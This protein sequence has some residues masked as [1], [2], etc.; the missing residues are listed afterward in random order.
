MIP[1]DTVGQRFIVDKL[2]GAGGMGAVYRSH[3]AET[4][5]PVAIKVLLEGR[6]QGDLLRFEREARALSELAHPGVVRYVERGLSG[7]GR[8]YLAMEWIEGESLA[9][10][11][12]R[13]PL[14][15]D[16]T[17][18]LGIRVAEALGAA[19]RRGIVHRDLKPSNILLQ[20]SA[21]DR[22]KLA[23]FGLAA[24]PESAR[25]TT[26][27][28]IVGTP[29]YMAPEQA[30]GAH[31][32]DARTDVFA[33][34]CVLHEC[35]TGEA[36]FEAH[37][38]MAVL[39]KIV[40]EEVPR[41]RDLGHRVPASLDALIARML[42]KDP[43]ARPEDGAAVAAI[44]SEIEAERA[45]ML[46]GASSSWHLPMTGLTG[47]EQRLASVVLA[48]QPK[49]AAYSPMALTLVC[50][51]PS[52]LQAALSAAAARGG[53]PAIL[54][55]GTIA[56]T[57]G[58]AG[59]ATDHAAI[60]AGCALALRQ[61]VPDAAVAIATGRAEVASERA[62]GDAIERAAAMIRERQRKGSP[63]IDLD[64]VTAGLLDLRFEV[65]AGPL[66]L[67]LSGERE[68][69]EAARTLLGRPTPFVGRRREIATIEALLDECEDERAARAVLVT[70][71]SGMGKSRLR[72]EITRRLAARGGLEVWIARGD[73]MRADAAFGVVV[74]LVRRAA[75]LLVGEPVAAQRQKLLARVSRHVSAAERLRVAEFLGEIAGAPFPDE[76]RVQLRAARRDPRL[77]SDQ[78]RRAFVD[79][80]SAEAAAQPLALVL[81][82]MHWGDAPSV[83]LIDAALAGLAQRPFLVLALARPE[84]HDRLPKL[85]RD[86]ALQEIRLT[87]LSR[88]DG[89]R[90]V[91]EVL[92]EGAPPETVERLLAR[93]Q[94]NV[95]FLEELL[96]ATA[97]GRDAELPETMLAM[98]ESR[99][100]ALSAEDRRLLRAASVLGEV[101]WRGG[102][103]AL[104]GPGE[105]SDERLARLSELEWISRRPTAKFRGEQEYAFRHAL[106]RE[107]AYGM[108]TADDRSL[109]H[110]L[111]AAWLESAGETDAVV[112]AE[113]FE[114]GEDSASAVRWYC[115]AAEQAVEGN[116]LASVIARVD[117]AVTLGASG[118]ALG[119]LALSRALAH[120]WRGEH[121][122]AEPW[123]HKATELLS[124]GSARWCAAVGELIWTVGN[125]GDGARIEQLGGALLAARS[126]AE[127]IGAHTAALAH[128]VTW[129]VGSGRY[130][131]ARATQRSI[132]QAF[133]SL[134]DEP[135]ATAAALMAR[136]FL[137]SL[138]D[139]P[140]SL[141][142]LLIEAIARFEEAGDRRQATLQRS[143]LADACNRLGAYE[144]AEAIARTALLDTQRTGMGFAALVLQST[145]GLAL[146][147]RGALDEA[148]RVLRS[149][150][151]G[152]TNPRMIGV[153][154]AYLAD[155]LHL[156]GDLD[157]AEVEARR[158][159]STLA[160]F[161]PY[162]PLA[163]AV[164]AHVLLAL[165]RVVK[166][167]TEA[168][169]ALRRLESLGQ[170]E[171]GEAF[172]RL[173][174]AEAQIAGGDSAGAR[175][176]L[177]TARDRLLARAASIKDPS[178]RR[179][180]LE[181]VPENARTLALARATIDGER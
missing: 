125:R 34:G 153:A 134:R 177:A 66:G 16:E 123:A 51:G 20:G 132:D 7:G 9:T 174:A 4:G 142:E 105:L 29:E 136:A 137:S 46:G 32:V 158:A 130:D 126:R 65:T 96:R 144:E 31:D 149:A 68:V 27:G 2:A 73:P 6:Q 99:L 75:R 5:A 89:E 85:W 47:A 62:V 59:L 180:F 141:R 38:V 41:L 151:E 69:A 152:E 118:E 138:E 24:L 147:R 127:S 113:H 10:R 156:R 87:E 48:K 79:W 108:L 12:A 77:R 64:D 36:A 178:F 164:R 175:S 129:L 171:E 154:R 106:V 86:R 76:G 63:A 26:S 155:A 21:L 120:N 92:G 97:E 94:G 112:L 50:P 71:P 19:H 160:G 56:V 90:L 100:V 88:R 17:I 104:L 80:L 110:R 30:R 78:V 43:K 23:D 40:F 83:E 159:V 58:G 150:I 145:L 107:A 44:L 55:D 84:I 166:A 121:A 101:F 98:V 82:D 128:A 3:D 70:A 35:I 168:S 67:E 176:V 102:L 60:A 181:K 170:V 115:T 103:S 131:A 119:R 22:P 114:R 53:R 109:G 13:G 28:E 165:G 133:G 93:S 1:G 61:A 172:V 117:R 162:L 33:L 116:D 52:E 140:S 14:T 163:M 45:A 11:L 91:R 57:V 179:S 39:V 42:A 124:P 37:H 157:E 161:P 95:F 8:P 146:A 49:R 54:A 135:A 81:E 74:Q 18:T 122:E 15:V 111:A 173:V 25:A 148:C 139:D 169:S 167:Q 143:N 72:H